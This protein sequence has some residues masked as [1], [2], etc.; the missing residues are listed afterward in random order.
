MLFDIENPGT[1][2]P[3]INDHADS[4]CGLEQAGFFPDIDPLVVNQGD[5]VRVRVG[6]P[7]MT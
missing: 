3:R 1:Y 7:T 4:T 2:I 5:N 6:Q